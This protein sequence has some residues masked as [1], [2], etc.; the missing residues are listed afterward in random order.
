MRKLINRNRI[1]SAGYVV[2]DETVNHIITVCSKLAQ[3]KNKTS[4]D[5]V[6]KAIHWELCKSLKFDHTSKWYIRKTESVLENEKQTILWD[7]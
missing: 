4:R 1:A 3:K 2:T 6:G 7:F 5:R